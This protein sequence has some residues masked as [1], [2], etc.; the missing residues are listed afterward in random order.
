M[1]VL[2]IM[3]RAPQ[4]DKTVTQAV[5]PFATEN[6]ASAWGLAHL[7]LAYVLEWKVMALES[8]HKVPHYE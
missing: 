7:P 2:L 4:M 6:D 3:P 8:P 1:F 5:G